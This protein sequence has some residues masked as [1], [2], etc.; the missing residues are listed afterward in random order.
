MRT[1]TRVYFSTP[2]LCVFSSALLLLKGKPLIAV[3]VQQ[4]ERSLC[5]AAKPARCN[6]ATL[7]M[8]TGA[9]RRAPSRAQHGVVA[10]ISTRCAC[11]HANVP[12]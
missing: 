5:C 4:Q 3:I 10:A 9:F 8:Y 6:V 12:V 7:R 2:L 11:V 1:G